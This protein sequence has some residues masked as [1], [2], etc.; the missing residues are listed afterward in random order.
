[1]CGAVPCKGLIGLRAVEVYVHRV[2]VRLVYIGSVGV[3]NVQI[4]MAKL[5]Q[6]FVLLVWV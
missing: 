5:K 6:L 4:H 3:L 1:M 2:V